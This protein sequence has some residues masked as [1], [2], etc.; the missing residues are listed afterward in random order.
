M[1]IKYFPEY[2]VKIDN[3]NTGSR[4]FV[5]NKL[6]YL[7]RMLRYAQGKAGFEKYRT[8]YHNYPYWIRHHD[9]GLL[10][11]YIL[12]N[13]LKL[14]QY[15]DAEPIKKAINDFSKTGNQSALISRLITL[16]IFLEHCIND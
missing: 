15:V 10:Y 8:K 16:N 12:S 13:D 3:L 5:S 9:K 2:F 7:S 1:L 6:N 14:Y 11:Q 4:L